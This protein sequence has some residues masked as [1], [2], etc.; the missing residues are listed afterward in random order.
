MRE[1]IED[2]YLELEDDLVSLREIAK[3]VTELLGEGDTA[4]EQ[5]LEIVRALPARGLLAGDP[6]YYPD[7]Y[8]PWPDERPDAVV[9]HIRAEW[10]ELGGTPN[11]PDIPWFDRP[12]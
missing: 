5:A 4:R 12:G 11:I 3:E 2:F 7:R 6:P 1:L 9:D 10:I 8:R